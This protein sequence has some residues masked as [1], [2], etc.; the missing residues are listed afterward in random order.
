MNGT[1]TWEDSSQSLVSDH[2]FSN[3]KRNNGPA[4]FRQIG[5][6]DYPQ[7]DFLSVASLRVVV[8]CL[9]VLDGGHFG[10]TDATR[11]HRLIIGDRQKTN[12]IKLPIVKN[13]IQTTIIIIRPYLRT[14]HI[15]M[16]NSS[17]SH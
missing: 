17:A 1:K 15:G 16:K 7:R 5:I 6:R 12:I 14:E 4:F 13:R 11:N 9:A 8:K 2:C 3:G 10:T